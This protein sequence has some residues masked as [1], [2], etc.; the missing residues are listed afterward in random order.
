VTRVRFHR[1]AS[2]EAEAAVRWYDERVDGLGADFRAE[3]VRGVERIAERPL[4]WPAS[5]HDSRARRDLLSRFPYSVVYVVAE[6]GSV[7]VA[8]VAHV[9]RRPAYGRRRVEP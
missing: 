1:A 3:L 2:A 7:T 9:K 8:A 5:E 6:D 4:L